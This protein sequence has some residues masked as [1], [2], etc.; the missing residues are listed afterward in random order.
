MQRQ[1]K[2]DPKELKAKRDQLRHGNRAA[3]VELSEIP[4]GQWPASTTKVIPDRVFR[5]KTF[6]ALIFPEVDGAVRM[7]VARTELDKSGHWKDGISWEELQRLK[8]EAGFGA[9]QAVEL[10]PPDEDVVN[11][12]NMRHL[13]L[14]LEPLPFQ[15]NA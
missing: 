12:A 13:W 5:S 9:M 2:F 14:M 15:W 1:P 11:V 6:L 3:T 10:Y 7:S 8:R 4:R